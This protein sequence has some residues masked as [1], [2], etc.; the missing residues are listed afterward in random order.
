[1]T[2]TDKINL[3]EETLD[4][5]PGLLSRETELETLDEWGSMAVISLMA[6]FDSEFKKS[7]SASEIKRFTTV[8]DILNVMGEG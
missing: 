8:E 3:L 2:I 4:V 6:M 1:M 7:V 5:E